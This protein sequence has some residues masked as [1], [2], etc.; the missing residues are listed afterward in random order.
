[1]QKQIRCIDCSTEFTG[2]HVRR[3]CNDCKKKRLRANWNKAFKK[4]YAKN[5]EIHYRSTL[6][7]KYEH[8]DKHLEHT[9]KSQAK[10]REIKRVLELIK[11]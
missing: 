7:W 10:R 11:E 4:W 6:Q 8:W 5:A 3:R 9:R 1:M 2:Y